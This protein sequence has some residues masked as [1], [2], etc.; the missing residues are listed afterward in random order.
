MSGNATV[1]RPNFLK[2][3]GLQIILLFDHSFGHRPFVSEVPQEFVRE[4]TD[5]LCIVRVR[6][7]VHI[8]VLL[9][10]FIH[11]FRFPWRPVRA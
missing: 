9:M 2:H 6:V 3:G 1:H 5:K 10:V 7:H 8:N 4:I 11:L